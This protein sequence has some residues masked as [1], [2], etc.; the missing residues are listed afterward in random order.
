MYIV[1]LAVEEKIIQPLSALNL[2]PI[3]LFGVST[4]GFVMSDLLTLACTASSP[5][6]CSY[7]LR[8]SPL[9]GFVS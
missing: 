4:V 6:P 3:I 1:T 7:N 8:R 9:S 5:G 2:H